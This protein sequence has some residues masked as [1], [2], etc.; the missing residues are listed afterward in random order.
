M[1]TADWLNDEQNKKLVEIIEAVIEQK[2]KPTN[3][4]AIATL[5]TRTPSGS[6]GSVGE[7]LIQQIGDTVKLRAKTK[8]GKWVEFLPD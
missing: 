7:M 3:E 6:E 2:Q 4:R 1:L 5:V 8:G